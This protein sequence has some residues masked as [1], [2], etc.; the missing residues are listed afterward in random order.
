MLLNNSWAISSEDCLEI[1]LVMTASQG[2][3]YL[4]SDTFL[5]S[6][7]ELELLNLDLGNLTLT[8]N[9]N[10]KVGSGLS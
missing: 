7:L 6:P 9:C 8:E 5:E 3:F 4:E 10:A 2:G 1:I